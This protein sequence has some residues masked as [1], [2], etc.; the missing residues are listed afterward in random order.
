MKGGY[1]EPCKCGQDAECVFEVWGSDVQKKCFCPK[2]YMQDIDGWCSRFPVCEDGEKCPNS[3]V[4]VN[5]DEGYKCVCKE[6]FR[7]LRKNADPEQFGC[8]DICGQNNC[9][10]GE[11]EV[12]G[13]HYHC[14]CQDGY[15]GTYCEVELDVY[16]KKKSMVVAFSVLA[17][18]IIVL[19]IATVFLCRKVR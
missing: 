13:D 10:R 6:G 16:P 7:R 11:C 12:T 18:L 5:T 14:R 19:L 3:T 17:T 2:G 8:E 4:C 15:A 9:V 1:C